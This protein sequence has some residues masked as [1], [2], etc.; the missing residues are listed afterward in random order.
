MDLGELKE[1]GGERKTKKKKH[2]SLQKRCG[3][4]MTPWDAIRTQTR[5]PNHDF[6]QKNK[7]WYYVR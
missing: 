4:M 2:V 6:R 1:E 5:K 7:P 3:N